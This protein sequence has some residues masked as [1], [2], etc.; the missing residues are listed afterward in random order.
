MAPPFGVYVEDDV[1][2]GET[3]G[4]L[5]QNARIPLTTGHTFKA[6][7]V[8]FRMGAPAGSMFVVLSGSV[9]V[10]EVRVL[11]VPGALV[12]EIGVFASTHRRTGRA[13]C[14][15]DPE[16]G[17]ISDNRLL[18]LHVQDPA[19][20]LY[21]MRLIVQRMLVGEPRRPA[22]DRACWWAS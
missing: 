18:Q 16:I 3:V 17:S 6:G 20:G 13:V 19:F 22:G 2:Q 14:E 21:L 7:D 11:L 1:K 9:R 12:G 8:L 15:M 5:Q 4:Q 10:A